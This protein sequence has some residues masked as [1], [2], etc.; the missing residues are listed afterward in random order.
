MQDS[1]KHD[2]GKVAGGDP[3]NLQHPERL[4]SRRGRS[5]SSR[6]RVGR[7][8]SPNKPHPC[9]NWLQLLI[10]PTVANLLLR[11]LLS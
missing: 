4:H 8:V 3:Q 9:L 10:Y 11:D 1:R 2:Q 6:K 5:D 7:R